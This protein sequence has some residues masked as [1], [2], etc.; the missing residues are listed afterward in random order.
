M[1][2]S[3]LAV[4]LLVAQYFKCYS[5]I[6]NNSLQKGVLYSMP[7]SIFLELNAVFT[8]H[9]ANMKLMNYHLPPSVS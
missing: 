9:F 2:L 1:S 5:N 3:L 4:M 8:L 7:K 6:R